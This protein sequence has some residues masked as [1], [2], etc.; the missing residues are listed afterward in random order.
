M[1]AALQ[2]RWSRWGMA[3][4]ALF[5]VLWFAPFIRQ[6]FQRGEVPSLPLGDVVASAVY[7]GDGGG[8]RMLR[9]TQFIQPEARQQVFQVFH[10]D[11]Q[12]KQLIGVPQM[13]TLPQAS[14]RLP[15]RIRA[16]ADGQIDLLLQSREWWRWN[17]ARQQMEPMNE[18]L[19]RRFAAQLGTG[20]ALLDFGGE[21]YPGLLEVTS[22]TG[23]HYA[24]YWATGE[25]YR[26]GEPLQRLRARAAAPASQVVTRIDYGE[27]R[28]DVAKY[29]A[30]RMLLRYQQ[31]VRAGEFEE[32]PALLVHSTADALVRAA[33]GRFQPVSDGY[34]VSRQSLQ[35]AGITQIEAVASV[36]VQ[37][38]GVVLA[39]NADRV[40]L[41]YEE[42]PSA[43]NEVTLQLLDVHSLQPVWSQSVR[44]MPQIDGLHMAAQA[45]S[46]GFY[47]TTVHK[48]PALVLD[49]DG[50]VLQD[51]RPQEHLAARNAE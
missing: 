34:V 48:L 29:G 43:A 25:I 4:F 27:F 23:D 28:T 16:S 12:S 42:R 10:N 31:K 1:S 22:N 33:P 44:A 45:W 17:A 30:P 8:L 50:R 38:A 13:I 39:R 14:E 19:A 32:L 2:T 21:R 18:A 46:G 35:E 36:P 6:I 49:N 51:F 15:G 40:L 5:F 47:L 24:V 11:L 20:V 37:M 9:V 3:L 7:A 41:R 26:W